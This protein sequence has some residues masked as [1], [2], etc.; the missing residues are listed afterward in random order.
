MKQ[1]GQPSIYS[2]EVTSL[3]Q[4][5]ASLLN[6]QETAKRNATTSPYHTNIHTHASREAGIAKHLRDLTIFW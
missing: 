3:Q 4:S 2:F 5:S 1:Q 6:E